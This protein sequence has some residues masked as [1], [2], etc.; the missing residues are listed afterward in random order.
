MTDKLKVAVTGASGFIGQYVLKSLAKK[1]VDVIAV[2]R[3]KVDSKLE[4]PEFR[5]VEMDIS[6]PGEN[7]FESMGSPDILIHLAWGGLPDYENNSHLEEELPI[8]VSFVS[9]MVRAGLKTLFV[10]GTCL[11]YGMKS[12][13]LSERDLPSP[14]NPYAIAKNTLRKELEDLKNRYEFNLIWSRLFYMYGEGQGSGSLYPL[15]QKAIERGDAVFNL[16]GG[17]QLRDYLHVE[18][19]VDSITLLALARQDFGIVNICSGKPVSVRHLVEGWLKQQ[20]CSIRLNFGY[21]PYPDYEAMEFWGSIK[22]L[23][24]LIYPSMKYG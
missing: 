21:Y 1:N 15:L 14:T 12:G 10:S 20:P 11:E 4:G 13:E 23:H 3:N 17:E 19:V 8:H 6:S 16:S 24:P 9:N 18:D 22:K 5:L 7:P 2:V